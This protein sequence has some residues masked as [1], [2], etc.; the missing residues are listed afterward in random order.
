MVDHN[1]LHRELASFA[2]ALTDDFDFDEAL[3]ELVITSATALDLAGAGV[4]LSVPAGGTQYIAASDPTTM[5][6]ER[7][8]DELQ[9]GAC[10]DAISSSEIVAVEDLTVE[11]RW[12]QFTPVLIDAGFRAAAGVPIRYRGDN[13]GAVN[14]YDNDSRVWT[15]DEFQTGRL[16]ADLAAGYLIN[17]YLARS[18]RTLARQ[19]EGALQSRIIIEQAKGILAGRH[20][21]T[22]DAA[23]EV[24]RSH[25][26]S[27][28]LKMRDV[29]SAIVNGEITTLPGL[30]PMT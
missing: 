21:T 24:L 7:R 28:R 30:E 5:H 8:Q 29:C 20:G 9:Q 19:L 16:I 11:P 15:I 12:P 13:I 1:L 18:A 17:S 22:P 3:H 2:A 27:H 6:V 4:T 25:A 14:L 26:R 10:I 23:F